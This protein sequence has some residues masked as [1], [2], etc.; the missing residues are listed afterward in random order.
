MIL[1]PSYTNGRDSLTSHQVCETGDGYTQQL[2]FTNW[3]M[4]HA[5]CALMG[6]FTVGVPPTANDEPSLNESQ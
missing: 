3:T 5:H 4:A 1:R 2:D 6:G